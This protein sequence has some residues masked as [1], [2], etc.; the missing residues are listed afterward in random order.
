MVYSINDINLF[1]KN[2]GIKIN[3]ANNLSVEDNIISSSGGVAAT[4]GIIFDHT[5]N[6]ETHCNVITGAGTTLTLENQMV[7]VDV[8]SSTGGRYI[9]NSINN[10]TKGIRFASTCTDTD[11]RSTQFG[12]LGVGL[13]LSQLAD[14]G[15]Q[16][17]QEHHGNRWNGSY[18]EFGAVNNGMGDNVSLSK[19]IVHTETGLF[20]PPSI[21]TP[22]STTPWFEIEEAESYSFRVPKD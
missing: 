4:A 22:F 19:F 9:C 21:S 20:H 6:C 15:V 10:A 14:F 3:D 5:V 2:I 13:Y 17:T 18:D 7:G 12:N 8:L 1:G 16:N 11:L